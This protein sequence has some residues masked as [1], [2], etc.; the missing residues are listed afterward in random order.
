MTSLS[1]I[2][3]GEYPVKYPHLVHWPGNLKP[4]SEEGNANC[5]WEYEYLAD[6]RDHA[7]NLAGTATTDR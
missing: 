4:C 3:S 2:Q 5:Y 1:Q 6:A 7:V